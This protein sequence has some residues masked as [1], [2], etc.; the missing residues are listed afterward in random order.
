M[1][2]FHL[3]FRLRLPI[4]AAPLVLA[5]C[6]QGEPPREPP[7][8]PAAPAVGAEA[9]RPGPRKA[10]RI[11]VLALDGATWKVCDPLLA[12]GKLPNLARL[13]ARGV[14]A[15]LVTLEPTVSPAIWT[16]IATGFLPDRHG[17]TG[18]DGVP[19]QT[20]TTLPNSRMRRVKA[21]WEILRDAGLTSG[22][23]GWWATWPADRLGDGSFLVSDRVPYTRMEAAVRRATL[24]PEDAWPPE[25]L[26]EVAPLVERPN[27]LDPAVAEEFLGFDRGMMERM[28]LGVDYKMGSYLPEFKFVYQSDRSTLRM[29]L[30]LLA[31]RRVDVAS[32][33]FTGIDTVSHLYWHFTYPK[34]FPG[35]E[36]R[37][38]DIAR[39]GRVIPLYYERIDE[40]LGQLMAAAGEDAT[41]VVVSDHGFGGTG[42]LPWSG[43]HGR[44]T[45]GAPIAP[46]GMLVMAGPGIR[47]DGARLERA[48]VLDIVPTMLELLG[49]PAGADMLGSVLTEALVPG[50]PE[51][52][53]RIESWEQVGL[54]R[55]V[56]EVPAE[57]AADAE[58][59]DR[60]RAL[61]YIQ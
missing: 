48:H 51:P 4:L 60:L 25:L 61:G 52:L 23:L 2:R 54:L 34:E 11:L 3:P 27:D 41:V 59:M 5:C 45:P 28:L 37:P 7:A 20:M 55:D 49:L 1:A 43:G 8:E 26:E 13:V 17:I 19:G 31:Q 6:A 38:E 16:T 56:G 14:R 29:A 53:P 33:Y 50:T 58:R 22:T 9:P 39:Y 47:A 21:Y 10:A 32:V 35:Q 24:T 46:V 15:D 18:F 42:R 57:P 36:I 12:A 30:H 44:L 40:Y